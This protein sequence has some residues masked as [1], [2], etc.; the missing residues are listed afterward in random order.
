MF[1]N[2]IPKSDYDKLYE[3]N[4]NDL[5]CENKHC[6]TCLVEEL[7]NQNGIIEN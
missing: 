3:V 2:C 5:Q 7:K 1:C 4:G 6:T